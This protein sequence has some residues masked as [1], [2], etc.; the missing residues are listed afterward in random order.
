MQVKI[1]AEN[2][3]KNIFIF[4]RKLLLTFHEN[5][6]LRRQCALNVSLFVFY[7]SGGSG[8]GGGGGEW[9]KKNIISCL[10]NLPRGWPR[11][12]DTPFITVFTLSIGTPLLLTIL[13]QKFEQLFNF[14]TCQCFTSNLSMCLRTAGWVAWLDTLRKHAYS[15]ILNILTTKK[16]KF[17]DKNSDIF[18]TSGQN[19]DYGYSNEYPQSMFL[20]RNK[21]N[22]VYPCKPQFH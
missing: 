18:Q 10:L 8:G 17:S 13:A 19:I 4:P 5:C 14:I 16:W 11:L 12:K 15:N 20:G 7:L 1:S 2:I 6:L 3:F 21:K 9:N 22:N